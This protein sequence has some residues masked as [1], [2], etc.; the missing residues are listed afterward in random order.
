MAAEHLVFGNMVDD[1]SLLALANF[2]T[3]RRFDFE[4]AAGLGKALDL[5]AGPDVLC[6]VN[7]QRAQIGLHVLRPDLSPLRFSGG[8]PLHRRRNSLYERNLWRFRSGIATFGKAAQNWKA[9]QVCVLLRKRV[10]GLWERSLRY[11]CR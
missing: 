1:E 9:R 7:F 2:V 10:R 11:C 3:D 6:V 8:A 4:F 5:A